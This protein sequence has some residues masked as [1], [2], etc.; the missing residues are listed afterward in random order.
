MNKFV[1]GR[2]V[3]RRKASRKPANKT[4]QPTVENLEPRLVPSGVPQPDHVVVVME[5]NHAYNEIIGSASAPYINSLASQYGVATSYVAV[6]HPSLPNYLAL[7]GGSTFGVT[8]DDE[9]CFMTGY[10]YRDDE[11][12]PPPQAPSCFLQD[13]GLLCNA[14]TVH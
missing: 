6:A 9:M 5:E 10:Y 1:S 3:K 12:S 2:V 4:M 14:T 7:T 8:T 11:S 13:R